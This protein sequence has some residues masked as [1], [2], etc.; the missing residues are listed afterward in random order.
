MRYLIRH[1][2]ASD[3]MIML[4]PQNYAG[5]LEQAW[6]LQQKIVLGIMHVTQQ[7][8]RCCCR[9]MLAARAALDCA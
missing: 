5:Y 1:A 7:V 2:E 6:C 3:I 4:F 9:L 8:R